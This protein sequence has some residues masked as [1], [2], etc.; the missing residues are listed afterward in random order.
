M[1]QK[2]TNKKNEATEVDRQKE[3]LQEM[4]KLYILSYA[5]TQ[6][7]SKK[8]STSYENNSDICIYSFMYRINQKET[9]ESDMAKANDKYV[10]FF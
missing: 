7:V 6:L 9:V 2:K 5:G 3:E 4:K 10:W 1:S 8:R